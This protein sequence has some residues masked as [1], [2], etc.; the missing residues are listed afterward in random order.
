MKNNILII[1]GVSIVALGV[2]VAVIL[3]SVLNGG[4]EPSDVSSDDFSRSTVISSSSETSEPPYSESSSES[5]ASSSEPSDSSSE[6]SSDTANEALGI[7]ATAN[8][9]IGVPFMENGSDPD[10]FD[11][12]GFIYYVLRENGYI[13]CPRQTE[14]QSRMGTRLDY[15]SIKEG[16]LVFFS[17]EGSGEANF[18]GIYVGDGKMIACLMPDTLV[19]EVDITTDYYRANFFGGVSL[20]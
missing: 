6:E 3:A 9:L 17:N 20:T 1:A 2:I 5:A 16:D 11:N 7:I 13:T 19:K 14:A 12:S 10:G 4:S 18:G 8:S 15:D